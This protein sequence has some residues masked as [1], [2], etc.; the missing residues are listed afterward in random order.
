MCEVSG[1]GE[2]RG[3]TGK[4]CAKCGRYR[5]VRFSSGFEI[6]EKCYWCEAL[7]RYIPDDVMR[8]IFK[9]RTEND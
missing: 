6:C 2:Y 8:T 3:Y 4:P 1:F 9:G 5:V 7:S